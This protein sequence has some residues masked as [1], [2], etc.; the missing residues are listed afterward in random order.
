[1]NDTGAPLDFGEPDNACTRVRLLR[2]VGGRTH[3]ARRGHAADALHSDTRLYLACP[4]GLLLADFIP[5]AGRRDS[6]FLRRA[7][8]R[9]RKKMGLV[10]ALAGPMYTSSMVSR[11]E[12]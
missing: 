11:S 1:M 12:P 9:Y 5:V 8:C 7:V 2:L 3:S 6:R 10:R 4:R